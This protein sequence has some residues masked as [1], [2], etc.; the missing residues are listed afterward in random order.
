MKKLI[1]LMAAI[2]MIATAADAQQ[3]IPLSSR[4]V[5]RKVS[6]T[7]KV[8][9]SNQLDSILKSDPTINFAFVKD[10]IIKLYKNVFK[11]DTS[12]KDDADVQLI[13]MGGLSNLENIS[14]AGGNLSVGVMFKTS[15]R[16]NTYLMFNTRTGSTADTASLVKTFLFPD[17]ARRDF[18]IGIEYISRI[19][20]DFLFIPFVEFS[21][22][23]YKVGN[24][25]MSNSFRTTSA[26]AGFKLGKS[27]KVK[28]G[29]DI[30]KFGF[31]IN[32]YYNII[33]TDPKFFANYNNMLGET[34]LP[35]TFHT[36]GVNA[37]LDITHVS[38]F[39]NMKQVLNTTTNIANGDLKGFNYVIGTLISTD[40]LK[41][42]LHKESTSGGGKDA[43]DDE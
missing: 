24:D 39:A 43:E 23:R 18:T 20:N 7:L 17:I 6:S 4:P 28:V 41:F 33:S 30:K 34:N 21:L 32:P 9:S 22:N 25:S 3:L 36:I 37:V 12:R 16:T 15:P 5:A 27:Y 38:L 1:T 31:S 10:S 42:K 19:G 35:P 29:D 13:G 8:N 14:A 2:A 26:I 11:E 40:I